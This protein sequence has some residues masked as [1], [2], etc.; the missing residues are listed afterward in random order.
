MVEPDQRIHL[1][2]IHDDPIKMWEALESVHL[3][4]RPGVRFNA[5]DDLFSIR[6]QEDETLQM[7]MNR[8][9]KAIHSIKDLCPTHFTLDGLDNKLASM[10]LI[11]A[12]PSDE[13]GSF[14]SSLLLLDKLDKTTIN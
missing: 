7:L 4:K 2:N 3:Q 8:V 9:D 10:S 13:Y 14:A 12:L 5:Y 1:T 11:R 6:K